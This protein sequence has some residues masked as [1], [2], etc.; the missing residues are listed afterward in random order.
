MFP[1]VVWTGG[2]R[3]YELDEIGW[4]NLL[5]V[6][7]VHTGMTYCMYFSA[8]KELPG[9]KAAILSY[10]DP[11]VAV[12]VSVTV[13]GEIM[14]AEQAVGGMLILG[15]TLFNEIAPAAEK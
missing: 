1:Y 9:Q 5:I 2:S 15:F 6:G 3:L 13:L 8:L 14:T 10:I 7:L 4:L 12:V 11:L